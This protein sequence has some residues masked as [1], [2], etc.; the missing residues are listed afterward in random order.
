MDR[1]RVVV[2]G[3][4]AVTPIGNNTKDLWEALLAGKSG[5][6]KITHFDPTDFDSQI[7][8]EVKNFDPSPYITN[9]K[10][11]RRMDRFVQFAVYSAKMAIED[12]GLDISKE[13]PYRIGVLVGSGIGGLK[14]IQDQTVVLLEKGPKR[15]APLLIPMLIVNMAPGQISIT[16]GIKGP[17]SCVATACATGNHSIGEAFRLIQHGYADMMVAGGT[18]AAAAVVLPAGEDGR[19]GGTG[20][21]VVGDVVVGAG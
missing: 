7:A 6:G 10:D 3:L 8:C 16:C 5:A 19:G 4:G 15:L 2:T 18:E 12:S 11:L 21:V 1:R 9:A 20:G 13:D 14:V 17:N